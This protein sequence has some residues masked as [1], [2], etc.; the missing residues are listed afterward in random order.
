MAWIKMIPE[1]EAEGPLRSIYERISHEGKVDNILKIHALHPASLEAHL[2]VY[3]N[4]MFGP[5]PLAR[6]E[7][8]MVAVVV[9]QANHCHY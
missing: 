1:K 4:V 8:E 2:A 9:S 6:A 7:R 3:T 5:G